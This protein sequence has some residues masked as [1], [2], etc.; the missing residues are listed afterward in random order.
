MTSWLKA[1]MPRLISGAAILAV[2]VVAGWVSF[3]HIYELSLTLHQSVMVARLMPVGIDGLVV[4]GSVVLLQGGRL[5][6]LGVGPGVGLSLFAN[7]ESGIRY[8]WLAA[9]WAGIPALSFFL[10]TFILENWAKGQ[11]K[12]TP[13]AAVIEPVSAPE[14]APV[15]APADDVPVTPES[16]PEPTVQSIPGSAPESAPKPALKVVRTAPRRLKTR[17]P[18]SAYAALLAAGELP[19]IRAI[20]RDLHVGDVRAKAIRA[21]LE[22]AL[23]AA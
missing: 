1:L 8:G 5:G 16:A 19:S 3:A 20:R 12:R 15:A 23:K 4:V 6:W 10:A 18:E 22:T 11:A 13:A 7:V 9:V 21:E 2:A 17:T 14:S